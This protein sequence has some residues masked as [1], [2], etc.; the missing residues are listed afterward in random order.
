MVASIDEPEQTATPIVRGWRQVVFLAAV[1]AVVA[2]IAQMRFFPFEPV[3]VTAV[4]DSLIYRPSRWWFAVFVLPALLM[5]LMS[6]AIVTLPHIFAR[7]VGAVVLL[8]SLS[9]AVV[10]P[11]ALTGDLVVTPDGFSHTAGFWWAPETRTVPFDSVSMI[12]VVPEEAKDDPTSF[13][14]E[15][16]G[17]DGEVVVIPKSTVLEAGLSALLR[18]AA[19]RGVVIERET[20]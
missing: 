14:L 20:E 1:C 11:T 8:G 16:H 4:G 2:L 9:V 13:L 6:I 18:R 15:C 12:R 5:L 10:A 3:S 17:R 19:L 7:L